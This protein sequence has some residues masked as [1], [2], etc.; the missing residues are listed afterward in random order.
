[1]A[2]SEPMSFVQPFRLRFPAWADWIALFFQAFAAPLIA[3][4]IQSVCVFRSDHWLYQALIG[5]AYFYPDVEKLGLAPIV[6]SLVYCG[7]CGIITFPILVP[8][9]ERRLHRWLVWIAT[10][11][12]WTWLCFS[13]EAYM[14][15]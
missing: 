2:E 6:L 15:K 11:A 12:V 5:G 9:R 10:I 14:I 3:A 7:I 4:L 1:M 8:F 13:T